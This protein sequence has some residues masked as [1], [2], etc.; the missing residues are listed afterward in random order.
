MSG[1]ANRR[2]EKCS[3]WKGGRSKTSEGYI[4]ATLKPE[5]DFFRPMCWHQGH[6]YAVLEHRLVMAKYL[7]RCLLPTERVH[8]LNGVKD[9]NRIGN[10]Q[11]LSAQKQ[12]K[13]LHPS[14]VCPHCQKQFVLVNGNPIQT[15]I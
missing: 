6:W 5:D 8:H 15:F 7:G 3:Q 13:N 12:H 4:K 9:D 2:A 11:L 1:Y 14:I 10:L